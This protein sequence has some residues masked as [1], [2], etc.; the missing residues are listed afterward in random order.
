MG[1]ALAALFA[2]KAAPTKKQNLKI[3]M[4][5]SETDLKLL[6]AERITDAANGGGKMTGHLVQDGVVN[7]LF[8]DISQLDR[9][10][11]R[12]SLRKAYM[13]VQ[14]ANADPY[15]GA[16]VILTDPPDDTS[17][18][19]ILFS[20]DSWTD[21]RSAARNRIESYSIQG[22]VSDWVLFG[23][24]VVGQKMIRAYSL[25]N[26]FSLTKAAPVDSFQIGDVILLSQEK[27][28]YTHQT[29]YIRIT[30]LI[31]RET[32][33]Y[34]DGT[35]DF[36]KDVLIFEISNALTLLYYG[37]DVTRLSAHGSPTLIRT[38]SVADAAE[39]FG[40]KKVAQA[41]AINDLTVNIGTPYTA[42]VPSAQAEVPLVDIVA[43]MS[44]VNYKQAGLTNALIQ[45]ASLAGNAAPDYADDLY[46]GRGF[47]PG[48]LALT[49]DGVAYKD[50]G[51]NAL[52]LPNGSAGSYSG[53]IDYA[54]GHIQFTKTGAWSAF[55][56]AT[57][58]AAV[59]L[60]DNAATVSIPITINNRAF[61]YV[62]TLS[63]IPS[64]ASLSIDFKVMNKWYRLS[65]DG[66]GRITGSSLGLG[67]GTVDY[68]T[69]S[70]IVTLGT[71]P[72]ID[73]AVI[74]SWATPLTYR[75]QTD[76]L[77]PPP[78]RL[79]TTLTDIPAV[80][81][82]LT[83]TWTNGGTKTA[84][85]AAD[86]TISGDAT[87]MLI[88]ET[89]E[90]V[91]TP[92][93]I[94]PPNTVF[95]LAWSQNTA[96]VDTFSVSGDSFGVVSF[97][98]TQTPVKPGSARF[99]YQLSTPVSDSGF[100]S[101][102]GGFA[103]PNI[104]QQ[105][106]AWDNGAGLI[107][108]SSGSTGSINYVTGAVS[109][110]ATGTTTINKFV[111]ITSGS[112]TT[113]EFY[114]LLATH[115]FSAGHYIDVTVPQVLPGSTTLT[116][117]YAL[118]SATPT[119][120]TG[121]ITL[122]NLTIDL[123]TVTND[124]IIAG[125][126]KFS[127]AGTPYIDRAGSIYRAHSNLTD[128]ATLAGSI[129][130]Q[131]GVVTLTDWLGG[132]NTLTLQGMVTTPGAAYTPAVFFRTPGA[133]LATGQFQLS[134]VTRDGENITAS[135]NNNGEII[136]EWIIGKIDWLSG[137]GGAVF[138]KMMLDSDL[139]AAAKAETWYNAANIDGDGKIW[140]PM[141]VKPE[142]IKF[143]AVLVTYI[144]LDADILGV[145]TVRL[146]LDGRVPVF[147]NGNVAVVHNTQSTAIVNPAVAGA[148][149][150][151]ARIRL[152][153]AKLYDANGLTIPT[154]RYTTNLDAGTI[155]MANPL[156]LTGYAQPL[157]CEHRIE[158]M[159][160]ITDVQI[161]GQIQLMKPLS[162]AYPANTSWVSSALIIGDLQARTALLFEQLTWS[163]VFSDL[164]I[165]SPSTA[166]FNDTLYPLVLANNGAIQ[167]RWALVF[168]GNTAFS[169]YGE[170]SGLVA[171]GSTA[172]NF[173]PV[174]SDSNVPYFT[175]DYRGWGSGWTAGNV[176]RINTL[177]ANYPLWLART[178]L[179]SSPSVFSDN[180]KLQIRGDAN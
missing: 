75:M 110:D 143:N 116:A 46:M 126:I 140:A 161:T 47:L 153:Y 95:N 32:H 104:E 111:G 6:Q 157:H 166:Q 5:I 137:V 15:L 180:F 21:E 129:D 114:F 147:R 38:V 124:D 28:G 178:T 30:K 99:T 39:Y 108:S 63:P 142:T 112:T 16:H 69:G 40:V 31:S 97:T 141:L 136:S 61:N 144:P 45:S 159:S 90:L 48:S 27:A 173:A 171:Q 8:N 44:K 76:V 55:I 80:P 115:T 11:G 25:S 19:V 93:L 35:G 169:C 20:T 155:T 41:L 2:A 174:N 146:P 92:T 120:K 134:A 91:L 42:L 138:G 130:Y 164:L 128:S 10:Y 50:N 53:I 59:A 7:N 81:G 60:Y 84:A 127:F 64:P 26:A 85:S 1:A 29:Q 148:T 154:D 98:L 36:Y 167:E 101:G 89:G 14:S 23:D 132:A 106:S 24:H 17:V 43:G 77:T 57:A 96:L 12:V 68:A 121:S 176:L 72:D 34:T 94:P 49:V 105:G 152:A 162:H 179:Q 145:E 51:Q 103:Q 123:T 78:P 58:T 83:I 66:N 37:A 118:N 109:F 160:L 13:S 79:R 87:G 165:G 175:L 131:T 22:P 33:L 122:S 65:D 150:D 133:P 156:V 163:N 119:A 62:Q 172:G 88:N 102:L 125:S 117:R 113:I 149:Y 52:V 170:Y 135:A 82:T 73:S 158:D 177:A 74:F 70:V 56:V 67:A 100:I 151:M 107:I 54:S 168:T 9:T 4:T 86:G 3:K 139:P 18:N 71:L